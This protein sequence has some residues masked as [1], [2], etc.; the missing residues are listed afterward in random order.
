M[1]EEL[2]RRVDPLGQGA[3][4]LLPL[5]AQ[6]QQ[7]SGASPGQ[8]A[9]PVAS[10]RAG[11]T[12]VRIFGSMRFPVPPEARALAAALQAHGIHLKIVDLRPGA[13]ISTEVFAWIEFAHTFLVFGTANYVS[14]QA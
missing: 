3:L 10:A 12:V 1:V 13:D 8:E 11:A 6:S 14:A 7:T 4:P 9:Q 5:A 2:V